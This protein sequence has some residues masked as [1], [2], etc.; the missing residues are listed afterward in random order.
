MQPF[1]VLLVDDHKHARQGMREIVS[2]DDD[3]LVVGEAAS[4]EEALAL[5]DRATP[6]LV[7]MDISMPGMGGLEAAKAIKSRYPEVK[8]V[9]V[10]VSDDPA[11]LFEALKKGAQGYLLKNLNPAAWREYLRAI[12]S[13]EAPLN[14][15]L[16]LS[17]LREFAGRS[18]A[19][20]ARERGGARDGLLREGLTPRETEILQ[21][22]ARGRTNRDIASELGLSEH[23]VKNHLKNI[24]QKLH[25]DNRVQLTRYAFE[26]GLVDRS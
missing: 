8:I 10:T 17:I 3:F 14:P 24:L 25:L 15:E 7:L 4:G 18:M 11:H 23:T 21:E 9:M 13:D 19:A 1:R 22:V 6:E 26:S 16:A 12:A 20:D 5:M 2:E